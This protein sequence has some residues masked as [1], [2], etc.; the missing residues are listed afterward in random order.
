PGHLL[1]VGLPPPER[2]Q[3]VIAQLASP[4]FDNGWG[5]RTLAAD[6]PR[7]N[8]M[9]YHN[10]SVWPHDVALCAAGMARYGAR[11]QAARLLGEVFEA[12]THFG[13]RLPELF[14]GFPRSAGQP[15]IAYPVACLPQ[16]WSAGSVFMLLPACLG[17]EVDARNGEVAIAHPQLPPG[18]DR[19]RV[20]RLD[21]GGV[22]VDL[23]FTRLGE[24]VVAT[25]AGG[26]EDVRVTVRT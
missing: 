11:R 23:L 15:P 10:G 18:V 6:Q 13:M 12:A 19:L 7:Y 8:P 9:S 25:R 3:R 1:Y 4:R 5:V 20:E 22:R 2:A 14:C 16:A 21:V 26:P 24:R 17:L